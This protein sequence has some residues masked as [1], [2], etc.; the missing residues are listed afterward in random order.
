MKRKIAI[1][2]V[3]VLLLFTAC[4]SQESETGD[5]STDE[6]NTSTDVVTEATMAYTDDE[7]FDVPA[8]V[9]R[10]ESTV[11]DD[12]NKTGRLITSQESYQ[13]GTYIKISIYDDYQAPDKFFDEIFYTI[14][15][16][17]KMISKNIVTSEVDKINEMAGVEPVAVSDDLWELIQYGLEY[18]EISGGK[19][20]ITIGPLVDL[21]G[22]GTDE[23]HIPTSDEIQEAMSLIDYHNVVLDETN[24]T[25]YLTHEDMKLD[26][27]AIAKGYIADAIK[28]VILNRGFDAAIINLGGNVLTV[29]TKPNSDS[30]AVGVRDP[31]GGQ[32]D[33]VG[34][35]NL[36]DNS[37]VSSGVYERFFIEDNVRYHHILNPYTGYPEQNDLAAISIISEKS[38]DGDGLST[39]LFVM[40]LEDGF[41]Y[42]QSRDDIEVMFITYDNKIYY[43][44]GLEDKFILTN[45]LYDNVGALE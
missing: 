18:S 35:L 3:S 41:A 14:D 45:T 24:Q 23:A 20:D 34:I 25:V 8:D 31:N 44:D 42:A 17:E 1:L 40:G 10:S 27:G 29:G 32:S 38:V 36:K 43:T 16:Y 26:L 6:A 11:I 39:S 28:A 5:N 37:I 15:N 21:W 13:I 33:I 19:F 30:W 4:Q 2:F 12:S 22:I 7:N 9:V